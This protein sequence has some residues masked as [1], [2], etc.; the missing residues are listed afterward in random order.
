MSMSESIAETISLAATI[1]NV[2]KAYLESMGKDKIT[3][4]YSMVLEQIEPPL[5]K[6]VMERCRYNQSRA[7]DLLGISRGTC[8]GKL[9]KYFGEQYCGHRENDKESDR[10]SA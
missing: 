7:A 8:R 9:I 10:E 3:N 4:L 2:V 5:F 1:E 6:A